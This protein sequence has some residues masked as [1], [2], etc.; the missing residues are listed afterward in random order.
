M[1]PT[2]NMPR[3]NAEISLEPND[4]LDRRAVDEENGLKQTGSRDVALQLVDVDT[5]SDFTPAEDRSTLRRIDAVLMPVMF[6]S[7]A[8]QYVDKACLTGAALFGILPD[9]GLVQM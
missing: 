1:Q 5:A 2:L 6:L 4:D 7:F 8:L 3:S 9:L